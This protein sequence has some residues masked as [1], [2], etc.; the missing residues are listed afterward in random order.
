MIGWWKVEGG[1]WRV[2]V[3]GVVIGS[4]LIVGAVC[5]WDRV[6]VVNLAST[7]Q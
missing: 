2:C 4:Q 6:D 5:A 3:E 1:R 7:C